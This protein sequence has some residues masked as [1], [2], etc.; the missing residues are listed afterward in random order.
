MKKKKK[1]FCGVLFRKAA[2]LFLQTFY[3]SWVFEICGNRKHSFPKTSSSVLN[4]SICLPTSIAFVPLF[5]VYTNWIIMMI[6]CYFW[7]INKNKG[8][9]NELSW[10]S[11]KMQKLKPANGFVHM[12]P[13]RK[14]QQSITEFP[15][16]WGSQLSILEIDN[17][18]EMFTVIHG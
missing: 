2:H 18:Y 17:C 8:Q 12:E 9:Q 3:S 16:G 13:V 10:H 4:S 7:F 1:K 6:L 15:V 11:N 14:H 5:N